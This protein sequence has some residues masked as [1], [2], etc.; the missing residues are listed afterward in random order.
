[1]KQYMETIKPKKEYITP[2]S[3]VVMLGLQNN[4]LEGDQN[5]MNVIIMCDSKPCS[6]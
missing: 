5:Y 2:K 6:D 3:E 1:M 4:L